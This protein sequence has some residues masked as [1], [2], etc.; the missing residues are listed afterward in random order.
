MNSLMPITHDLPAAMGGGGMR[1]YETDRV[2][3]RELIGTMLRRAWLALG[4]ALV[5]FVVVMA[6]VMNISPKYT[7]TGSVLIDPHHQNLTQAEPMQAGMPPDTSAVDT[8][9]EVLRS[10]ALVEAVVRQMALYND[11]EFNS[12][13]HGRP[14]A[15]SDPSPQIV[16]KVT[17]AVQTHIQVKRQG[18]T[19]VIQFAFTSK[20]PS[21]AAQVVNSFMALYM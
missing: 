19:Y 6:V 4:V 13:L 20:S 10:R 1:P 17:E 15:I 7:A 8:Q 18:L 5:L 21:R 9:V 14:G 3:L 12:D 11:P 2:D 16:G